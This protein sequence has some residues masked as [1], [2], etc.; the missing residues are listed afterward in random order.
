M[1]VRRGATLLLAL[2]LFFSFIAYGFFHVGRWLKGNDKPL[3]SQAILVLAGQPFRALYAADL[4]KGG[5]APVVFVSRPVRE[6]HLRMLD[7]LEIP[8]PK[9]EGINKEILLRRGVPAGRIEFLG[10]ASASTM[11]EAHEA[12]KEF[13][14]GNCSLIVVT[15]PYHVKRTQM[16]FHA[17]LPDCRIGVVATPYEP[18]PDRW[19]TNGDTAKN[20]VL[21]IG[22]IAVYYLSGNRFRRQEGR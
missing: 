1:I 18:Y 5:F 7:E 3:T 11:E 8:V 6:P 22:K 12:G 20:V 9:A 15:S 10:T 21:E 13:R 4:F 19:W 14:K 17:V 2:A 16:I